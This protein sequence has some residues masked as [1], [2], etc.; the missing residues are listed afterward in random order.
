MTVDQNNVHPF[1]IVYTDQ[2]FK[3][4]NPVVQISSVLPMHMLITPI[5]FCH[6]KYIS[7]LNRLPGV[8][9]EDC[10]RLW[11]LVIYRL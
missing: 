7:G 3:M 10:R 5:C 4:M 8:V 11:Q 1:E 9:E 2:V 6:L